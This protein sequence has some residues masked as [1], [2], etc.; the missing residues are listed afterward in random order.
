MTPIRKLK[1]N[2]VSAMEGISRASPYMIPKEM[3]YTVSTRANCTVILST[4]ETMGSS[5]SPS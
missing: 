3:A 4:E 5:S 1:P 2:R